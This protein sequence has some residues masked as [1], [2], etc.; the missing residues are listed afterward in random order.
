M[1]LSRHHDAGCR[2]EIFACWK[3][4]LRPLRIEK[5]SWRK[6][7][8]IPRGQHENATK[9]LILLALPRGI[10]PLFQP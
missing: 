9:C 2:Q 6:V 7:G 1:S 5:L 4:S 3:S 8:E 10:E